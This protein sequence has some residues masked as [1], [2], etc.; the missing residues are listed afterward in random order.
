MEDRFSKI[1]PRKPTIIFPIMVIALIYLT[2]FLPI[3]SVEN[4][5]KVTIESSK[6]EVKP[7]EIF[8]IFI[9]VNPQIY[10]ISGGEIV[11]K[12]DPHVFELINIQVG[13]LFGSNPIIGVKSIDESAGMIRYAVARTDETERPS[14]PGVFLILTFKTAETEHVN[15][16]FYDLIIANI[17]LSDEKFE[18]ITNIKVQNVKIH[19]SREFTSTFIEPTPLSVSVT[20]FVISS[21][22]TYT[23][24]ITH[25][26]TSKIESTKTVTILFSEP[27]NIIFG[28]SLIL[29]AILLVGL[30]IKSLRR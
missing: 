1:K 8:T 30:L 17:E 13:D 18:K 24:T 4:E 26:V 9:R 2:I 29:I 14:S 12:Y 22:F 20:T 3:V 23:T 7:G 10:G 6:Y 21:I 27:I 5:V 25:I 15:E 11:L 16:G 19:L 28:M